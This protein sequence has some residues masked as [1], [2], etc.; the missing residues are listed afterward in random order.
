MQAKGKRGAGSGMRGDT[1][2][3][4]FRNLNKGVYQW[5]WRTGGSHQQFQHARKARVS[6]DP[7]GMSLAEMPNEG[8][9]EPV[10]TISRV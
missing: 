1:D 8:E 3:Q 7:T 9:G 5:R 2:V 6:Q 4:R 10:H